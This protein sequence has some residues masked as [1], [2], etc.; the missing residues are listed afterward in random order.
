MQILND[1]RVLYIFIDDCVKRMQVLNNCTNFPVLQTKASEENLQS[2]EIKYQLCLNAPS[3]MDLWFECV[4][5]LYV[6]TRA[7]AF[8]LTYLFGMFY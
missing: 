3:R 8:T 1:F 4:L 6:V 2:R 7:T 5:Y